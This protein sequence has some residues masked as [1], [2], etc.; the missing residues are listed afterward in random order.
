MEIDSAS[1][2]IDGDADSDECD[3]DSMDLLMGEIEIPFEPICDMKHAETNSGY[4]TLSPCFKEKS[5]T[6]SVHNI[7]R[8]IYIDSLK[9]CI[10]YA[11]ANLFN[12]SSLPSN[13]FVRSGELSRTLNGGDPLNIP[14]E[15]ISINHV[16]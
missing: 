14:N 12:D 9:K 1:E 10:G 16:N 11:S 4:C 8:S 7:K 5:E 15:V 13:G 6:K 3:P 2:A